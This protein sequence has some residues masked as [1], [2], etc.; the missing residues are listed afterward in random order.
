M[1]VFHFKRDS[2]RVCKD[3]LLHDMTTKT[4]VPCLKSSEPFRRSGEV[5]VSVFPAVRV[6]DT[7]SVL[8]GNRRGIV[9]LDSQ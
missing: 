5:E 8:K 1:V 7:R 2:N 3:W 9:V 6:D 4:Q